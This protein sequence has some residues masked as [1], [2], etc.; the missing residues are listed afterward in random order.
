MIPIIPVSQ[1]RRSFIIAP[2]ILEQ[3]EHSRIYQPLQGP[4]SPSFSVNVLAHHNQRSA[5]RH[6]NAVKH[7]FCYLRGTEDLGL[8]YTK[9]GPGTIIGYADV[10]YKSDV[11]SGRSQSDYLFLQNNAPIYWKS[12]KQTVTATSTNHSEL[13]AFHAATREAVWLHMLNRIIKDQAGL[14]NK[15][16]PI[17]IFEDNA[18]CVT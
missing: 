12:V 10:G 17:T 1:K 8:H 14:S 15:P 3:L 4:T 11:V 16:P 5:N 13:I 9:Q 2:S 6:W 7:L 18:A